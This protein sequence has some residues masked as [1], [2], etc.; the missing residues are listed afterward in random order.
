MNCDFILVGVKRLRDCSLNGLI[1]G[2]IIKRNMRDLWRLSDVLGDLLWD[3]CKTILRSWK[4]SLSGWKVSCHKVDYSVYKKDIEIRLELYIRSYLLN[5][6]DKMSKNLFINSQ[7][8]PEII[9]SNLHFLSHVSQN[10]SANF[11]L[12]LQILP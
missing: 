9:N 8:N 12:L 1:V 2:G 5:F 7:H 3:Y 11:K 4:V 6:F 10:S